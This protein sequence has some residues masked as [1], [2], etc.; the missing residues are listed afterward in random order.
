MKPLCF[1]MG[2]ICLI[3][4]LLPAC[5]PAPVSE[6]PAEEA[7]STEADIEAIKNVIQQEITAVNAGDLESFLEVFAPDVE[8]IPPN[9]PAVRGEQARQWARNFMGQVAIQVA[10]SNEEFTVAGDIG[11]HRCSLDAT[12][13]PKDGG[14]SIQERGAGIHILRRQPDGSW[15]IAW[16]IWNTDAPPPEEPT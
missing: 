16:D 14:D 3:A 15:K 10:Y 9:Q 4:L 5:A 11:V 2:S 7:P 13:S 12:F 8:I 1:F 6:T